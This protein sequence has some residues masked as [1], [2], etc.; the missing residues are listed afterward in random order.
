MEGGREGGNGGREGGMEGGR[1]GGRVG[2]REE[3]E[4]GREGMEGGRE[5]REGGNGG[6]EG[7]RELRE[8]GR[9]EWNGRE[10]GGRVVD[11]QAK[12]PFVRNT[13]NHRK[14]QYGLIFVNFGRQKISENLFAH[15]RKT[16]IPSNY[17]GVYA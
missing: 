12:S 15:A 6:R 13:R 4:G 11:K 10:E 5:R 7:G 2:G 9:E 1:E 14:F 8:G 17:G 16:I 3:M